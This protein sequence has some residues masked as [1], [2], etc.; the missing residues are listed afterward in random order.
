MIGAALLK[1]RRQLRPYIAES[2][3]EHLGGGGVTIDADIL[4]DILAIGKHQ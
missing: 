4:V 2:L 1:Y 3:F